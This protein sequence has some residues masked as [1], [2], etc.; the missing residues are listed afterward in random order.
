MHAA[1]RLDVR[2]GRCF[3]AI[4]A[5]RWFPGNLQKGGGVV[6]AARTPRAPSVPTVEARVV[7]RLG[8]RL[9]SAPPI[10]V[11]ALR[12][13]LG[14]PLSG[15]GPEDLRVVADIKAF[16]GRHVDKFVFDTT[17][18]R[19]SLCIPSDGD[20]QS[21]PQADAEARVVQRLKSELCAG[22][23]KIRALKCFLGDPL[24]GGGPEDLRVLKNLK[25]FVSSHKDT[26]CYDPATKRLSLRTVS[27]LTA[28]K[29]RVVENSKATLQSGTTMSAIKEGVIGKP[30]RSRGPADQRAVR[31]VADLD[32]D[33]VAHDAATTSLGRGSSTDDQGIDCQAEAR[34]IRRL[35]EKL[36]KGPS[37]IRDLKAFLGNPLQGGRPEDLSVLKD[38]KAFMERHADAFCDDKDTKLVSLRAKMEAIENMA[39]TPQS[40]GSIERRVMDWDH[41]FPKNLI[42][43]DGPSPR[44]GPGSTE[45]R[46]MDWNRVFS[47]PGDAPSVAHSSTAAADGG[48][49]SRTAEGAA[50]ASGCDLGDPK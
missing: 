14:N 45:P 9:Q 40:F 6:Q 48:G 1:W 21:N 26:F 35:T 49:T 25:A 13:F 41:V 32:T 27:I 3:A 15:G 17:T 44:D 19:V 12:S 33:T 37:Y 36:Q 47:T 16:V 4:A 20:R 50:R 23:V 46:A 28:A 8:A 34:V 10:H 29:A 31:D 2:V 43:A 24:Q 42:S 11:S 18:K 30:L 22:P 38:W 5:L 7:E 39:E